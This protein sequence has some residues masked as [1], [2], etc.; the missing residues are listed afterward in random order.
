MVRSSGAAG[1]GAATAL[2]LAHA[3]GHLQRAAVLFTRATTA[4][5]PGALLAASAEARRASPY[6][7]QAALG[8]REAGA[9]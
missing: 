8:L 1:G 2:P 6:L 9:R 7:V 4:A 5:A 3:C